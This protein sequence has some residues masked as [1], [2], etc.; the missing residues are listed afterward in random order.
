MKYI[1]IFKFRYLLLVCLL[2]FKVSIAQT[3]NLSIFNS[4]IKFKDQSCMQ[5]LRK[6][7]HINVNEH[8]LIESEQQ[9]RD[10][11]YSDEYIAGLDHVRENLQLA[12]R[13]RKDKINPFTSHIEEFADLIDPHIEF[14]KEG[15]KSQDFDDKET[16]LNLL[17]SLKS[18]AQRHQTLSQVTYRWWFNFNLRLSILVT[19]IS[20]LPFLLLQFKKRFRV[21]RNTNTLMAN[22]TI[23]DMIQFF[24]R[25][26]KTINDEELKLEIQSMCCDIQYLIDA[27]P[28]RIM[29]PTKHRLGRVSINETHGTKVHFIGLKNKF[30][31]ADKMKMPPYHFFLHDLVHAFMIVARNIHR[32]DV[33]NPQ[34]VTYIKQKINHFSKPQKELLWDVFYEITYEKGEALTK[35]VRQPSLIVKSP[36]FSR[37]DV[38]KAQATLSRIIRRHP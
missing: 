37:E 2:F 33:D 21:L 17:E 3:Q 9:L 34:L 4:I 27:F 36:D 29:I 19:P 22:R 24:H 26:E 10:Q 12:E 23:E 20:Q 5:A 31:I 35:L 32:D 25:L 13:L 1:K 28:E 7:Q 8:P 14:I 16:K 15:I 11:G 38:L 30:T 18:E 6:S